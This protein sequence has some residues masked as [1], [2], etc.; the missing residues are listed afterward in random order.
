MPRIFAKVIEGWS[1]AKISLWLEAEGIPG[2]HGPWH[3]ST[4]GA[5]IRNPAYM[6]F[7]CQQD[8]KTKKYGQILH[9]CEPLV[10][11]AVW[12][13]AQEALDTRPKR[14]YSD[15]DNRPMLSGVL[16]CGNPECDA[17]GAPDSPMVRSRSSTK[18][19][20]RCR[21]LGAVPKSCSL[22]VPLADV[23]NAVDRIIQGSFDIPRMERR[24]IPGTDHAAERESLK[25]ELRQLPARDLP[26]DEEDAERARLRAEYDRI[27]ELPVV[28]DQVIE[29]DTGTT[30]ANLWES[31]RP[32]D[33]A[34]WLR[35]EGFTVRASKTEVTVKQGDRLVTVS[36]DEI[37]R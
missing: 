29:V 14:G 13:Q 33:R 17:S 28:P 10:S 2:D 34:E 20:Y 9:K 23:D 6:G 27:A 5:M 26:W 24:V 3:E 21:G 7:R 16:K 11:P 1:L 36:L 22:M 18:F 37:E 25:F 8:P 31:L 19:Y 15:P 30:Y 35:R 4:I 32:A 12:R